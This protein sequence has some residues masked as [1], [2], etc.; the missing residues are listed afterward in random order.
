M[1]RKNNRTLIFFS[2]TILLAG[3]ASSC[4]YDT[5]EELYGACRSGSGL[6]ASEVAKIITTH[7]NGASCHNAQDKG[8]DIILETYDQVR[9]AVQNASFVGS[10][11]HDPA[12]IAMP[13]NATQLDTCDINTIVKWYNQGSLNN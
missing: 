5:E 8:G 12:Y 9:T 11:L 2:F 13:M 3:L 1:I 4:Y 7:C 6:Y 10:L